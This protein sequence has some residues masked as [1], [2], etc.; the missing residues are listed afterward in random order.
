MKIRKFR[1]GFIDRGGLR[2]PQKQALVLIDFL[3]DTF[4]TTDGQEKAKWG[5]V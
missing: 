5:I 1:Q 3:D 4:P 2:T